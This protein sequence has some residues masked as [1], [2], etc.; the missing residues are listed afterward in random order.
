MTAV[1]VYHDGFDLIADLDR[2]PDVDSILT[3]MQEVLS[4]YGVTKLLVSGL[5]EA[6]FERSVMASRWPA[7]FFALYVRNDYIRFDPIAHRGR[8]AAMPFEWTAADY[9]HDPEPRTVE[10]MQRAA[11]FGLEHGFVVPINTPDGFE[12]CVGMSGAH[13]D[14]T[15]RTKP[16]IHLVALYGYVRVRQLVRPELS[17]RLPLTPREHEV[18]QWA[19]RGKSAWEIGE[20]LDIG[21]RTV[22][23]HAAAAVRK[24]GAVNRAQAVAIAVRDK[25]I[26]L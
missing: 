10:L 9:Y 23:E 12:A 6:Q 18:L 3:R 20:I 15:A 1:P 17:D 25:L 11:D 16:L 24:L 4:R 13:L 2:M 26:E 14:L 21:K 5:A 19:A 22:E 8:R 7:E